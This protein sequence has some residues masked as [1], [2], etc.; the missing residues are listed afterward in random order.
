MC[1]LNCLVDFNFL[2]ALRLQKFFY[3]QLNQ[4]PKGSDLS[5]FF[6]FFSSVQIGGT[7]SDTVSSIRVRV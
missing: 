5:F 2:L 6:F 4:A 1:L 7:A 3:D